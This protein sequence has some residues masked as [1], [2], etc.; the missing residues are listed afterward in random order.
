MAGL[1]AGARLFEK[2][3]LRHGHAAT[4]GVVGARGQRPPGPLTA[5]AAW[6]ECLAGVLPAPRAPG[7]LSVVTP[8]LPGSCPGAVTRR[9]LG[10]PVNPLG[11]VWTCTVSATF[12][13]LEPSFCIVR[14]RSMR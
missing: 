1:G 2:P 3:G 4:A 7:S 13:L 14:P 10:D 5:V 9:D 11:L 8:E 6:G 12:L